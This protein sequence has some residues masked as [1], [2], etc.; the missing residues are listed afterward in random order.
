[1][2]NEFKVRKGLIVQGSGSILSVINNSGLPIIEAF[3]DNKVKIGTFNS[4]AIIVNGTT[5]EIT[6][7]LYGTASWASNV[8][9][10]DLLDGEHGSYYTNASNI[11]AGTINDA[12]LPATISSDITGN[13]ATATKLATARTLTIGA[14]GK[15]FDGSA[16]VSWS[17]SDIGAASSSHTHGD[18]SNTGTISSVAVSASNGD[19]ILISD[20]SNSQKIQRSIPIGTGTTTYLRNDGTWSTPPDTNT[21][22]SAATS[23]TL[24]LVRLIS[25]TAQTVASNA[26]TTTASR[27]YAV[28]MSGSNQLVVNVPWVDTNTT[29]SEI[30]TS[31]ITTTT[32]S[33][34]G[35]ITGRRIEYWANVR[36]LD[37]GSIL[38]WNT[39][40]GDRLKWDGG[41]EGLNA[42]TG[43]TSLGAN[44]VGSNL[45]TLTNPSAVTFIRINADNTVSALNDVDFRAA[46]KA[47]TGTVTS[48]QVSGSNG[49]SGSG[50]ITSSGSINLQHADT[51]TQSSVNNSG[52]TFIQDITL[53]DFGHVTG[54]SSATDSDTYTGTVTSVG[55]TGTVSGISLTGNVTTSGNLTLGGAIANLTSA[56]LSSS[57]GITNNQLANSSV[58]VGTTSIALGSSSTTLL[59]LN[60]VASTAFSGAFFGNATSSSMSSQ[61]MNS[62]YTAITDTTTGNGPYYVTFVDTASGNRSQLVDSTGLT[63]NA[64]TNLLQTTAS[65]AISSSYALNSFYA[66][67]ASYALNGGGGG[68]SSFS[69]TPL[70]IHS[71]SAASTTWTVNHNLGTLFPIITVYDPSYNV[72]IP[73]EI[74]SIDTSSLSI[75][76]PL[77]IAGYASVAGTSFTTGSGGGGGSITINDNIN[78]YVLTA[79]GTADTVQGNANLNFNGSK[80]IITGS[81]NVTQGITGSLLGTSSYAITASY[82]LNGGGGGSGITQEQSIINALIF[83]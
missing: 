83:G 2:G 35:L 82:A 49:L 51:S 70:Y 63:Y 33:T 30:S 75:T 65:T 55:G 43:R 28:Q 15:T 18:I 39:A 62:V 48:V 45:F 5:A 50:I 52:R 7:S 40:Y 59:G 53:D 31:D 4:E 1:M 41:V 69:G 27:T 57:A 60:L 17:L 22:Y 78:G 29:Y 61:S 37:T 14:T 67:T 58:T 64:T 38:N 25:D 46:I 3:S 20:S 73:Q 79:T 10:S 36:G 12:Y 21:T 11:N 23:T 42:A 80:L 47:G 13:S 16:N 44:T 81:L 72:V 26:I 56:N 74:T 6:G 71:Q 24:G 76:F 8:I 34:V 68:S 9:N 54:I 19:Y 32:S 77:S 66:V